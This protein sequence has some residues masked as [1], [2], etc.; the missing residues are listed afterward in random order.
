MKA[1]D[2]SN[3]VIA[4]GVFLCSAILLAA[5]TFA[6]GGFS[7]RSGGRKIIVELHDA[8]GI[9][10]HSTVRY[11]G[12]TAGT[13]SDIRYL[14][15]EE[16]ARAL[17]PDNAVR[18]TI[19][20]Q[21]DVPPLLEGTMA[22]LG[23]ETLLG[24]KFIALTPGKPGARQLPEPAVIQ[25][26]TG[27]SIDAVAESAKEAV[28]KVNDILASLKADYPTL[29]PRL[30]DL[31]KQG[32]SILG[33]G[34][35]VVNNVDATILNAN[36]AVTQLKSDYNELIPKLTSIF[37]Q[38]QNIATNADQAVLKVSSLIDRLD[39]VVTTNEADL[40]KLVGE[41]RIT[42]QNLKVI[43]TYAKTLTATL[44]EKPSSLIWSRKKNDLPDE[45]QILESAEPFIVK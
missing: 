38:A 40:T 42:S 37:T 7:W 30:A 39:R 36:S 16:R 41:L 2:R 28:E 27:T 33:Q 18:V 6:L 44:A 29:I 45:K 31:L 11:A 9:K 43:T 34:S 14:T 19:L 15:A 25:G 8:T 24:E 4:I 26:A 23:A 20:L 22:S 32:N 13:V 21:D 35:N 12:K 1:Q 5:L 10:L 3:Y 17:D